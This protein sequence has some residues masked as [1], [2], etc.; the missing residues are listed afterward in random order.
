MKYY[1]AVLKKYAVFK[2]RASRKEYWMFVLF[3]FIFSIVA[4]ILD[5]IF[6][7]NRIISYETPHFHIL[8]ITSNGGNGLFSLLYGLFVFIPALAVAVRRLHDI[9]KS[10]W[11]VLAFTLIGSVPIIL[12]SI[13]IGA[14]G[15]KGSIISRGSI[16]L[17]AILAVLISLTSVVWSIVWLALPGNPDENMYGP[18]PEENV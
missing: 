14:I 15:Y 16:I 6:K 17:L 5:V 11:W 1:L 3:Y 12:I 18:V 7:T 8:N 13:A 10:G 9:G 2:G 4:Q